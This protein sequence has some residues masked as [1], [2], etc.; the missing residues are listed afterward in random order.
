LDLDANTAERHGLRINTAPLRS[1]QLGWLG[2]PRRF[3][4][5]GKLPEIF[6]YSE[7]LPEADWGTHSGLLTRYGDVLPLLSSPDDQFVVMEHGEEIALSFDGRGLPAVQPG[8]R[9]TFFFYSNGFTKGYE[10]HSGESETV[11][12]LPFQAMR[13]YPPRG[14]T[15]PVDEQH[16]RYLLEWNTRPSFWRH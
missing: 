5:G 4:Q 8:W 1:A 14:E 7:I 9:R 13:T 16:I 3:L 2:Y 12:T 15:Y 10:L 6:K 11:D